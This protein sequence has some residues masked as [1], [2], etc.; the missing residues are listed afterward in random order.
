MKNEKPKNECKSRNAQSDY[1]LNCKKFLNFDETIFDDTT[2]S[3]KFIKQNS[4]N[5]IESRGAI[6]IQHTNLFIKQQQ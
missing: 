2:K 5:L 1:D 3:R 4:T 6:K